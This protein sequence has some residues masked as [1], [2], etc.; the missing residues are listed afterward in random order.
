M[1]GEADE[2]HYA[3]RFAGVFRAEGKDVAVTL[4]PGIGH[5]P[6]TVDP[7]AVQASVDAVKSMS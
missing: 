3:D 2:V 1:A 7:A 6:L 5:I 4:L